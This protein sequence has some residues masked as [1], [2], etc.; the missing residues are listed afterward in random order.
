MRTR[1]KLLTVGLVL[2]TAAVAGCSSTTAGPAGAIQDDVAAA[3]APEPPAPSPT[4]SS[5]G[6]T[7]SAAPV[8]PTAA[9]TEAPASPV[10][11]PTDSPSAAD[12]P[13]DPALLGSSVPPNQGRCD[14]GLAYKCGDIGQSRWGT[15]FYASAT[16]FACGAKMELTCNYLEA[17][18]NL[19]APDSTSPC[20]STGS[21]CGGSSN[22]Q[23]TSDWWD[24]G[25]GLTWC[26]GSGEYSIIPGAGA[27]G[28]GSGLA[29]TLAV[30][31]LCNP[32][33]AANIAHRFQGGGKSDWALPS[34][35]ELSTLY[36]YTD[37]AAIGG[38][39]SGLYWSSSLYQPGNV[40]GLY[41]LD[42]KLYDPPTSRSYGLRPVRAF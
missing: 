20:K 34:I 25:K 24:T 33:D 40:L 41:F 9:P 14:P 3:P 28:I 15:V 16:P 4:S 5:A 27:E 36:Y 7:S 10:A 30:I 39:N 35:D 18:Q 38:F 21:P 22:N 17:A 2:V 12:L 29:N 6:P 23:T 8:T 31:P 32:W 42:H 13:D 11:S 26:T 1:M 19:W 37:R